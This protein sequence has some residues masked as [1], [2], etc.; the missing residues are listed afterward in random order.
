[1]GQQ[2]T[3]IPL[4]RWLT[5][6]AGRVSGCWPR[7]SVQPISH[8]LLECFHSMAATFPSR[9]FQPYLLPPT[10][11]QPSPRYKWSVC[12]GQQAF[13]PTPS[14]VRWGV[15]STGWSW[16]AG[17]LL[18]SPTHL[19]FGFRK[20]LS[21]CWILGRYLQILLFLEITFCSSCLPF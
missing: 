21:P 14:R 2:D 4:L 10:F 16:V 12:P 20:A 11:F 17:L 7:A 8:G 18:G 19:L 9:L 15:E 3:R 1:M 6:A 13:R 5:P